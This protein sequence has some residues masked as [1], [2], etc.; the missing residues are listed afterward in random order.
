MNLGPFVRSYI[1]QEGSCVYFKSMCGR[2]GEVTHI[3]QPLCS[4][5][6]QSSNNMFH[7]LAHVARHGTIFILSIFC[8][9]HY[10]HH[11]PTS[12]IQFIMLFVLETQKWTPCSNFLPSI[13]QPSLELFVDA[14]KNE[15]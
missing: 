1:N 13:T 15:V 5:G 14:Y 4:F 11:K 3:A 2:C 12:K 8:L 10:L 7:M 6:M 9:I